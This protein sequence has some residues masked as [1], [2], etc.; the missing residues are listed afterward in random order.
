MGILL[1]HIGCDKCGSK[2]NRALY[3]DG[4]SHCFGCLDTTPSKEFLESL[5]K[6]KSKKHKVKQEKESPLKENI[7]QLEANLIKEKTQVSAEDYRGI[8]D[9][10]LLF[11]GCRTELDEDENVKARYY[12]ITTGSNLSGY[13]IRNHPKTFH[14]IGNVGN[15]CD[16]YGTFRFQS[17]G[18]YILI[19]GGEEDAHAAY[20]MFK[21]YSESKNSDFVTSVVSVTTGEGSATKQIA[22]N[23]DFLNKFDHIII[24]FDNDQAGK[25][26]VDKIISSLPKGKVKICTWSKA[27][28]PNE[29]L[30]KGLQKQFLQDFYNAKTYVPV[31]VLGSDELYE[32]ILQQTGMKKLAFPPFMKKLNFMLAGGIALGHI[33]NLAAATSIGKTTLV[34]EIVYHWVFN[35]PHKVGVLSMEADAGQ[36][37]E[38]L[39]SRHIS[40]KLALMPDED[41]KLKFIKSEEVRKAAEHLFTVEGSPRFYI[42]DDRDGTIEQLQDIIEEMVISSNCK[43]IVIDP[44]QDIFSGLG[45][46]EQELFMSWC[47]S[48]VKSHQ[49]TFILINHVRKSPSGSKD[50]SE[51]A[52]LSESDIHG[53][54][55]L[56]KSASV[57][58]L[59]SRNKMAEDEVERNTTFVECSKNRQCGIT[60]PAGELYYDNETHTLHDKEEYF[61]NL[62]KPSTIPV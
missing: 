3:T 41:E 11:Y 28:D 21:E 32:K 18:K 31:G 20:Q 48:M 36:Y 44:I 1:K 30:E 40:K 45:N 42:V 56:I 50:G 6:S 22:A 15:G 35:S 34:N 2:D 46:D 51:G 16:L 57:N 7:T 58:I 10:T 25:D 47:K 26:G 54:S 43:I 52:K 4:S 24:G 29:Y 59:L 23:Y 39:L 12:P 9:S 27:K 14:S 61:L 53:T 17:G 5:P 55:T 60:G 33:V 13:K 8:K 19:T 62:S 37:G 49:I 38:T